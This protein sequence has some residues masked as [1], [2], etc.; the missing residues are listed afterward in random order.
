MQRH[1]LKKA[2]LDSLVHPDSGL[3]TLSVLLG[4]DISNFDLDGPLPDIAE[5]NASRSVAKN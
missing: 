1:A 3:A 4:T 2:H 5:S